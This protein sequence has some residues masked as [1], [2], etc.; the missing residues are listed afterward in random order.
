MEYIFPL[1]KIDCVIGANICTGRSLPLVDLLIA[2]ITFL[3]KRDGLTPLVTRN[4]KWAGQH[5]IAASDTFSR[6]IQ[7][8][9]FRGNLQPSY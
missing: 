3:H 4:M 2:K 8:G 6:I 7:N 9:T 5:A 1:S